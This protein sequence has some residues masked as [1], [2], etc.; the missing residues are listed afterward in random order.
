M[1]LTNKTIKAFLAKSM[2]SDDDVNDFG[3]F[4][5]P[6]DER[7]NAEAMSNIKR[8]FREFTDTYEPDMPVTP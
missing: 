8:K 4:L 2:E 7:L 5:I 1:E 6:D 3:Y